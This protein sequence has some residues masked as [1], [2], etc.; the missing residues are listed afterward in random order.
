[1]IGHVRYK[2]VI[3]HVP[4]YEFNA[5]LIIIIIIIRIRVGTTKFDWNRSKNV[6]QQL[7]I[8]VKHYIIFF[9][10]PK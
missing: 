10:L 2:M 5:F 9:F 8:Y 1:M 4:E 7:F 6:Y 3:I